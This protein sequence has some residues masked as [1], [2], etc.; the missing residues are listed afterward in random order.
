MLTFSFWQRWLLV[1]SFII[2]V[3][4]VAMALLNG[5]AVFDLLFNNQISPVFWGAETI[6][7]VGIRFQQWIYGVL[8]ATVAGWGVFLAFI[9]H[10]PFKAREK[11]AWNCVLIGLLL[12]YLIDTPISLYFGVVFNAVFNTLLLVLAIPPLVFT[13]K[14][15]ARVLPT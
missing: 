3:F 6:P 15:F 5:T 11:W 2:I 10:Y 1:V 8:G 14:H 4:G 12:W 7:D 13:R 9:A